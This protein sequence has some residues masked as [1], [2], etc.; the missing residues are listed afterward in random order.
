VNRSSAGVTAIGLIRALDAFVVRW[1]TP[2]LAALASLCLLAAIVASDRGFDISDEAYYVLS[3]RYAASI[4]AYISP[5]HWLLGPVW[6]VT[7]DLQ[8]FRLAGLAIVVLGSAMLAFGVAVSLGQSFVR[9]AA[10]GM[11]VFFATSLTG[12]LVYLTTI[13]LSPSYNLIA[14]AG[15]IGAVGMALAASASRSGWRKMVFALAAG[16]C[17]SLEFISKPSSGIATFG[18][19]PVFLWSC[20]ARV[21]VTAALWVAIG[22]MFAATTLVV[23]LMQGPWTE[24]RTALADGL[25]LFRVVQ[26]ESIPARLLRYAADYAQHMGWTAIR[27]APYL[28]I[29]GIYLRR[30]QPWAALASALL[31]VAILIVGGHGLGGS[32][33][34]QSALPQIEG[35]VVILISALTLAWPILRF[36]LRLAAIIFGL[37]LAPYSVAVGTGNSIFT[38]V[39]VTLAPWA[40]A[41]SV[42]SLC[43]CARQTDGILLRLFAAVFAVTATSQ[44]LTSLFRAP[45]HQTVSY[46]HQTVPVRIGPLGT[47]RVDPATASFVADLDAAARRC[48]I[49]PGLP[50]IG[51]YDVPGISL[52]FSAVPVRSPWINNPDQARMI[53]TPERME[54][55]GRAV[56]VRRIGW[57]RTW[58]DLLGTLGTLGKDYTFCGGAVYP[59]ADQRVEVWFRL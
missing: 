46:W 21:A 39:I 25:A 14:S 10:S 3:G 50:Y 15:C 28:V 56:L 12:A 5:Q 18:L 41:L 59:F 8:T 27:F 1:R 16:L 37:V 48:G 52:A 11:T 22:S 44:I 40:V 42:M 19:L 51:L 35:L 6:A 55:L 17:L 20:S 26:S 53:L 34:G 36:D 30:R 32:D 38:Q 23:T 2:G 13:N 4:K 31:L 45:Y 9:H 49:G 43:I 33:R 54:T 7:G 58:P 47:V 29:F 24:T 57:D